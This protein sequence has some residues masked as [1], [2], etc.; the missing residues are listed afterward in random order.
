MISAFNEIKSEEGV[1]IEGFF[2]GLKMNINT[3]GSRESPLLINCQG[4]I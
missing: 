1:I 2:C 3:I 4:L